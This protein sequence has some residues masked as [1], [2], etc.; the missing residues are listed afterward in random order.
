MELFQKCVSVLLAV[1][2]KLLLS[3][4]FDMPIITTML[5]YKLNFE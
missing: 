4:T 3:E 2:M 1:Y 5:A